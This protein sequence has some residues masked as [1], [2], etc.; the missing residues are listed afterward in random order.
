MQ[1]PALKALVQHCMRH[2]A[3]D[4]KHVHT[5]FCRSLP[6]RS[7]TS[8]RQWVV[9]PEAQA[10][11]MFRMMMQCE[12]L[13]AADTGMLMPCNFRISD[14]RHACMLVIINPCTYAC[15]PQPG[16][17]SVSARHYMSV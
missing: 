17:Q 8:R 13:D 5:D 7:H 14:F 4:L 15:K 3:Q 6:A 2:T 10:R 11:S 1:D 16:L 12:R 9:R